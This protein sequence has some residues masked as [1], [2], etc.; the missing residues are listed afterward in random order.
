MHKAR[1]LLGAAAASL[2]T[3]AFLV[4]ASPALAGPNCASGYHCGWDIGFDTGKI[5]FFNG[6]RDFRD[7]RFHT[8]VIVD[9]N[10]KTV[11][12]SSSS[13]YV[14]H[15]Y[16]EVNWEGYAFCVNPGSWVGSL[17]DDG[18]P[19]NGVGFANEASSVRLE[20]GGP[21]DWCY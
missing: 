1:A 7:N 16:T 12:N 8:G 21:Y 14:S 9:N 18:I 3:T 2:L 10:I 19:G 5:S 17:P 11:S 4:P 6:D 20:A 15:W 13:N